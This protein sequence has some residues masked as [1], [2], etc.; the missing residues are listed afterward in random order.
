MASSRHGVREEDEPPA[1]SRRWPEQGGGGARGGVA[2]SVLLAGR[3]TTGEG[4]GAAVGWAVGEAGPGKWRQVGGPGR[5]SALFVIFLFCFLLFNLLPLFW[6]FKNNPNNA[7]NSSEYFYFARWTFPKAHKI[8]QGY[9]KL[10]SNYMNII[11]IQIANDLNS[12]SQ[13]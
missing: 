10:Y 12:K 1:R 13:D 9:L 11:Q 8:F 3:K 4:G 6:N 2:V 7:K 5:S